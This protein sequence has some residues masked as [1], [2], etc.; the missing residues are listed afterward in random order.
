MKKILT[1]LAVLTAVCAGAQTLDLNGVWDFK[2]EEGKTLEEVADPGFVAQDKMAVPGCFDVMQP[3]YRQRGTALYRRTL[4]L[5]AAAPGAVWKI[6]GMG[7]RGA[8]YVDGKQVGY[9]AL[10]YSHIEFATGPLAEGNHEFAAALDNSFNPEKMKLFLPNY[11]FYAFG[12][13]Y[14]GMSLTIAGEK[15]QLDRVLVR[16]R[17][18]RSGKVELELEALGS[19]AF[20]QRAKASV[21]F[22]GKPWTPVTFVDGRLEM[23]V[24]DFKLWSPEE[25]NL[26]TVRVKYR[27]M[28]AQARFG[29]RT[30]ET[31]G[32]DIL[33]NGKKIYLQGFNRHESHPT[34]GAATPKT[35]MQ[36]DVALIKSLGANF[37]RGAHYS[38]SQDFL[39]LCDE[40]GILVWEE[41]LGWGNKAPGLSDP[42]FISLQEEQTRIMVRQSFNHP[43][44][45]IFAFL[46]ENKSNSPEGKA[47]IDDLIAVIRSEDSGRLVSFACNQ[48]DSKN[49]VDLGNR[50]TDIVSFNTYPAWIDAGSL[51]GSPGHMAKVIAEDV[52]AHARHFRAIYPDKPII[53][54]EM[55]TCGIYGQRDEAASQWSEEFQ[56]EYVGDVIDAVF[57]ENEITGLAIWHFADAPSYLRDGA[58]VRVKPMALNLAGLYDQ[59]RRPKLVTHTVREKFSKH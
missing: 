17:D 43:S 56:A 42:E 4:C 50:N 47:L 38:Q 29:I 8:F 49:R 6:E 35:L 26:H 41:S 24:P 21:S 13:F 18:Y 44:V 39:D 5:D 32:K 25:P 37:V 2:F 55:G 59:Y 1:L 36:T 12:G 31:R 40:N 20:P 27:D 45:I 57:A 28:T 22:D 10:P 34:F 54:S 16:T 3:Y 7:L 19:E 11:D 23:N 58:S 48:V 46:N 14:R 30:I 51:A 53:V 33:L 9:S 52:A 15:V